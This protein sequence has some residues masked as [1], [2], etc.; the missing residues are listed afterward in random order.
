MQ[1]IDSKTIEKA[2]RGDRE[3]SKKCTEAG[4]AI[5]CPYCGSAGHIVKHADGSGHVGCKEADIHIGSPHWSMVL[6]SF[7]KFH[8]ERD[9][10]KIWN[11][12]AALSD[13]NPSKST[14]LQRWIPCSERLPEKDVR[15]V[16]YAEKMADADVGQV[17]VNWGWMCHRKLTGITHWMPLPGQHTEEGARK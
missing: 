2:M 17:G 4:V 12:R 6:V 8:S 9:A 5:P 3:A 1:K 10:L 13:V 11:T 7:G 15:V 14:S 16:V